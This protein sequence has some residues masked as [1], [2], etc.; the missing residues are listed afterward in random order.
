MVDQNQFFSSLLDLEKPR[1]LGY[2]GFS[3]AV[4]PTPSQECLEYG[5]KSVGVRLARTPT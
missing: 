2:A 3:A 5:A 1:Q 4:K